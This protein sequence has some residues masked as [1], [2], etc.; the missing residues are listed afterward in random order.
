[1]GCL[2]AKGLASSNSG[3][4]TFLTGLE[5]KVFNISAFLAFCVKFLSSC[6]GVIFS[7]NFVLSEMKTIYYS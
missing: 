4:F 2:L 3:I 5:K 1:M 7:E 6:T